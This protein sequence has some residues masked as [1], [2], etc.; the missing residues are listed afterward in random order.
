VVSRVV[1]PRRESPSAERLSRYADLPEIPKYKGVGREA[2]KRRRRESRQRDGRGKGKGEAGLRKS[3]VDGERKGMR[4][5]SSS[6]DLAKR[7]SPSKMSTHQG[8]GESRDGGIVFL[9]CFLSF[10]F[11]FLFAESV[12]RSGERSRMLFLLLNLVL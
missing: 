9:C 12:S 5:D 2:G 10:V 4:S 8:R 6:R 7:E 11:A 1:A 3:S